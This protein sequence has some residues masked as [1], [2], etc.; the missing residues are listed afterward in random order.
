MNKPAFDPSQPF[1]PVQDMTKPAFDPSQ[2][3]E[4]VEEPDWGGVVKD[5]LNEARMGNGSKMRALMTDPITQAKALP[6]LAG[7]AG[8]FSGIP[9]GATAGQVGGRLIS[10]AALKAY[11]HP[12][13]IPS[14]GRQVAEGGIAAL[15]DITAFPAFNKRIFGGQVGAAEKA[16][17]VPP[18]E[19]IPSLPKPAAGQPVSGGIDSAIESVKSA[20]GEGT[21]TYWKQI[22]DQI[23]AF[24]NAGKDAKLSNLDRAKLQWLNGQVQKGLNASVAGR[25]A[26]AAALARSQ[27]VPNAIEG[28]WDAIPSSL[29]WGL[30]VGGGG[31]AAYAGTDLLK[32]AL[33]G[34]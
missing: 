11:G 13:D 33:S 3:F 9:M 18:P 25:A 6:Y 32:R 21:P 17:G 8:G 28:A 19:E 16:A 34:Q 31:G 7:T 22:K 29:K 4:D 27:A 5:A 23:D 20:G 15:G 2:S 26:P 10:D 30:G 12:E 24:Y 14:V 1:Q